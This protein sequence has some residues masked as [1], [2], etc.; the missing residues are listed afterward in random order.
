MKGIIVSLALTSMLL[1]APCSFRN[2]PPADR[3]AFFKEVVGQAPVVKEPE[4]KREYT[5]EE[6]QQLEAA[7]NVVKKYWIS[8][9]EDMY[10]LFS[11]H[12]RAVLRQV[13]GIKNAIEFSKCHQPTERAWSRQAY[14][15]AELGEACSGE[16]YV[17][18]IVLTDWS[19]EGYWGVMTYIFDMVKEDGEWKINNIM[20]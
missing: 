9:Y 20:Y 16:A 18:I 5:E 6:I 1:C 3:N 17:Q 10:A 19:E 4:K 13:Y 7:K 12:Y 8:S 11:N 2:E 14:Q 15:S